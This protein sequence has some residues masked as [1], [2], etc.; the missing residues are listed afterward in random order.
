MAERRWRWARSLHVYG[1]TRPALTR[2]RCLTQAPR[3]A[4]RT[5]RNALFQS[6]LYHN[7]C[8]WITIC[9]ADILGDTGNA[10]RRVSK[11]AITRAQISNLGIKR[12]RDLVQHVNFL[13]RLD[14]HRGDV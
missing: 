7:K 9:S 4:Q 11:C 5:A 14:D 13:G 8:K 1:S 10:P 6:L 3:A 12:N 2:G